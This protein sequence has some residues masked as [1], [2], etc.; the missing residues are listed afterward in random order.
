[1]L[2]YLLTHKSNLFLSV[3]MFSL[4]KFAGWYADE[5]LGGIEGT[6]KSMLKA[7]P[8]FILGNALKLDLDFMAGERSIKTDS[9]FKDDLR[10]LEEMASKNPNV[11][12]RE[13]KH[14]DAVIKYSQG[15]HDQAFLTWESIL[16]GKP[17]K[18]KP[19]NKQLL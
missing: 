10:A 1:M 6:I 16:W 5:S 3:S 18:K 4:P 12:K 7:D 19:V 9:T 13:L 11:T 15:K 8:Q 14:V 2:S 17:H